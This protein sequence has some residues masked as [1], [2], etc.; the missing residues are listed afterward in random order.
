M[1][2][3]HRDMTGH[4]VTNAAAPDRRTLSD[5]LMQGLGAALL[6]QRSLRYQVVFALS[7]IV[8]STA[9]RFAL[10]DALPPGF[11]FLTF[12]PAV[13]LTLVFSSLRSGL[14]VG[15][16]CGIVAWYFFIEPV[17]SLA[18]T[19]G[20]VVALVLYVLIIATDVVFITAA[21]RA[22]EQRLSAEQRANALAT[23]RSLMFSELQHRISNN[24]STVAALLR[25]QSQQVA[26]ETARQALVASQTRIR[27]IS[28]LQRRLHSPDLQT[29][30]AAEYLREVLQDVV[31]VSGAGNVDLDF[32]ADSLPLPHDTA[33]PLGLI[34]SELVMNAIEHGAH[35]GCDTRIVVGLTVG[36]RGSDGRIPAALRIADHGPGLPEGFDLAASDSLGLIVARQFAVALNGTLSLVRGNGGGTVARLDFLIDPTSI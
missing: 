7:A 5:K 2:R 20:A 8:L 35:D 13:M 28:L 34:A 18:V 17:R 10:D 33:V 27:S 22:L 32:S 26:D 3:S 15:A 6:A 1:A 24:L 25:L 4:D 23:S 16:V 12:F 9:L 14:V 19:P 11:P 29:L 21:G 30:D 31:Q 36:A